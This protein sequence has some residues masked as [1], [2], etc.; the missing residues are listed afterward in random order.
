MTMM[1]TTRKRQRKGRKGR[2]KRKRKRCYLKKKKNNKKKRTS[3]ES[4]HY[5]P[6]TPHPLL[7]E[8]SCS[9]GSSSGVNVVTNPSILT[10]VPI[11]KKN[12]VFKEVIDT[13]DDT[14]LNSK[15]KKLWHYRGNFNFLD[16]LMTS[17]NSVF[18]LRLTKTII[19]RLT[20]MYDVYGGPV[21]FP[22][23]YKL[24]NILKKYIYDKSL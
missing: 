11:V 21:V 7:P 2:K 8:G 16:I 20:L 15:K 18:E 13:F 12:S 17:S 14:G 10:I 9:S 1:S 6:P 24:L 22:D 19:N 3:R 5:V 23:T 4:E